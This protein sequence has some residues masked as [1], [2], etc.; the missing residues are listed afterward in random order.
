MSSIMEGF[1]VWAAA[2]IEVFL[3]GLFLAA[4]VLLILGQVLRRRK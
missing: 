2:N 1:D 4:V 3:G